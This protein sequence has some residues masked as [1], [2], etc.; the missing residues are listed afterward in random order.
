MQE[1]NRYAAKL[2]D[3]SRWPGG[4]SVAS[5]MMREGCVMMDQNSVEYFEKR[6]SEE[7]E[8]AARAESEVARKIHLDLADEYAARVSDMRGY[9]SLD[10]EAA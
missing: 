2:V 8:A 7:R 10:N 3:R 1:C 4:P 9:P 6:E 5:A